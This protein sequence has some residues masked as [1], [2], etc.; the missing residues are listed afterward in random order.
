[1]LPETL[2]TAEL[3]A[4]LHKSEKTIKKDV[5]VAPWTLPPRV[6]IPGSRRVMWLRETVMEWLRKHQEEEHAKL[7]A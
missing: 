2:G 1:M 4:L 7:Y 5:T 3:A 6:R